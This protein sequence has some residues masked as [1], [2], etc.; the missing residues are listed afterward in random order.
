MKAVL[1]DA[2][3]TLLR[4]DPSLGGVYARVARAHGRE[5]PER[6]F[7]RAAEAAFHA[8]AAGHRAA[9]EQGLVTSDEHERV[10]WRQHARRVMDGLPG[11][12]GLDFDPWFEDLYGD[13]GSARAWA[14]YEDAVPALEALRARG[15]RLAVVSN[16]DSRLRRI[17]EDHG[18]HT[19]FDAVVIS[20]E[21]GWRKPHPAI[22]HRALELLGAGPGEVL[23]VGDSVGDDV[24]GAR[25]AGIRPVL[26]DRKGG[27]A[28]GRD[29]G[30]AEVIRDLRQILELV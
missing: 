17:L 15:L 24:G 29:P 9:G 25:A 18:L 23:H 3:L 30:G 14:P 20:A 2:G 13:F 16:W 8:Q 5:V 28:G 6:D 7:E 10:S 27:R 12:K 21:V 1:L 4:A 26:L 22:F 19:R 11:M